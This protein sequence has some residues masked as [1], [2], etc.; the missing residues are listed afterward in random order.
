M[1]QSPDRFELRYED[2]TPP[3]YIEMRSY[4]KTCKLCKREWRTTA[5]NAVFC[6][7]EH[8]VMWIKAQKAGG[9]A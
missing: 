1:P 5:V 4:N 6:R 8:R 7:P 3:L 2:R 9:V